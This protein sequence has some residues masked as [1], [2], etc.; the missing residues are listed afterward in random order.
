MTTQV[1]RGVPLSPALRTIRDALHTPNGDRLL[2]MKNDWNNIREFL[3]GG[4]RD[5]GMWPAGNFGVSCDGQFLVI[6]LSIFALEI[7]ARYQGSEWD[8]LW[9]KIELDLGTG[10]VPW[11]LD[12]K[13]KQRLSRGVDLS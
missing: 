7:E 10:E 9:E 6:R 11:V 2:G 5:D 13:G 8:Q 3:T 1:K 4:I 12:W